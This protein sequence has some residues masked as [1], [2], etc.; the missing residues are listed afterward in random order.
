MFARCGVIRS[1][2]SEYET[3]YG[4]M[5]DEETFENL[6]LLILFAWVLFGK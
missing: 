5:I 2:A 1:W 4:Q 6:M 3:G